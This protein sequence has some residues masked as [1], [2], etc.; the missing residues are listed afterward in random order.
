MKV[1]AFL[2][3]ALAASGLLRAESPGTLSGPMKTVTDDYLLI[4][5]KLAADSM[6]GVPAAAAAMKSAVDKAQAGTF[7]PD[8][9]HDVGQL[10]AAADL[11]AARAALQPVSNVLIAKLTQDQVQTGQ[12][13][14]V[15][16]PMVKAY[17]VQ[18]DGKTVHNPYTGSAMS[19][20][21]S[22]QRQF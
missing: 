15:F 21:G 14:S 10:A 16:C 7:S 1:S 5:D 17:W 9:S 3:L 12:L 6:D 4:T 19:D 13:H 20:C 11:Q 18:S 22:F 8:F 2:F